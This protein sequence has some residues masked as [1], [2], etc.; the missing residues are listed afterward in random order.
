VS[1]NF[2]IDKTQIAAGKS[3]QFPEAI[4]NRDIEMNHFQI[5]GDTIEFQV[6]MRLK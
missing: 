5:L 4:M 2:A 3:G 6:L 1:Q